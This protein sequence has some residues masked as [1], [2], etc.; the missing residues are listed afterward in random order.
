MKKLSLLSIAAIVA[1]TAAAQ[2][3]V[4]ADVSVAV[5]VGQIV[6]QVL[7][8]ADGEPLVGASVAVLNAAVGTMTDVNGRFV[9]T[10]AS[11]ANITVSYMGYW[12]KT[13]Q[14]QSQTPITIRLSID[15][16]ALDEVVVTGYAVQKR[17][18]VSGAVSKV[19]SKD[20]SKI[21]TPSAQMALQGRVAGV[22][23]SN[24]TGAPG[25][26]VSVRIRGVGSISSSN[27]PLY[28]VDGIPVEN[29]LNNISPGD[30]DNI[31]ILKDASSA[32]IYGAR[33]NNGVVLI[34]TKGGKAGKAVVSYNGQVGFQQHGRLTKMVNTAQYVELYNEAARADNV[35][36]PVPRALIEGDYVKD[37][38]DVN[39]LQEIFRIA[40][41]HSHELSV[42]G[43]TDKTQYLVGLSYFNQDGIILNTDYSRLG[44]RSNVNSKVKNWLQVGLN[45]NASTSL[46]GRVSSSGDGFASA[47]DVAAEGS[48]VADNGGSV[49]RYAFFRNPAI[50]VRNEQGVFVDK[51]S[52][53][54]GNSMY[55]SFFGDGYNPVGL[56]TNTDM[57]EKMKSLLISGNVLITLPLNF[58][59]KS[60]VGA[61][62]NNTLSRTFNA[63][64]GT[65]NRINAANSLDVNQTENTNITANATLNHHFALG[66]AHAFSWFAGTEA[67]SE[68]G[69][70]LGGSESGYSDLQYLGKGQTQRHPNQ[71]E[72]GATLLSFF[73]SLNYNY[74]QKYY[75]SLLLREDGSSRFAAGNRWGTFYSVSGSWNMES[76]E[77]MKSISAINKL[78]LRVGYGAIGNQNVGL[79]AN[80]SRYSAEQYYT[81]GGSTYNGYRMSKLGNT[82][83]KWETS[84]QFNAGVDLE[85]WQGSVG[86]AVDY[87][88]KITDK[89]LVAASYPPSVGSVEL[90]WVN[91]GSVLNTGVDVELFYRKD[92]SSSGFN[93]TLNGGFLHNEVL[94]LEAPIESGRVDQG[95]NATRTQVGHPIGAFYLYEMDGIFQNEM[96][97]LTSAY[98][99]RGIKPGDVKYKD[100]HADGTID[101]ADRVFAGSAIPAFTTG[102]TLS[103]YYRQWDL[104]VFFQGAFGQKIYVQVN[105]DIE[106]FYRGFPTTERYYSN[107]WTGEGSTNAYP[108][109]SWSAAQNNAKSGTTRFLEDGSY[110]RL[111]NI[112]LGYTVPNSKKAGIE[113]LR[114]YVSATNLLTLTGYSGLDPEMTASTNS[115]RAGEGDRANGIDWGTYPVAM[116]FTFGVNI[117]F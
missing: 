14:V 29:G 51:P 17:R 15:A 70:T 72:W 66:N 114:M 95:V 10:T 59:I 22:Q 85:L 117:T 13:L 86:V 19:D 1:Y 109:A 113:T 69:Q 20:L 39:Y 11:P 62:Y 74:A 4:N 31:T 41:L 47:S 26:A 18:D 68:N 36:A 9:L 6:G 100:N 45:I 2:I 12:S 8:D 65:A 96:E 92:F 61:D 78:K 23:V 87:Y 37:F 40:P 55:D 27:D 24:Q 34:T 32:A 104:S 84:K 7:D 77:F 30:I 99:G 44:V 91:N 80:Q 97:V 98:Q 54:F 43:G 93:I 89:M 76:E 112:Q 110:F 63:T 21:P 83:L 94:S 108:R 50:P 82:E 103:G 111:K 38:A 116:C 49:V 73:G 67:I 46:R 79:Y 102:L 56:A 101:A 90:P 81:F 60:T 58:S 3:N 88:Y 5:S 35:G 107:H 75:L 105:K 42:S 48:G 53:Y 64:W 71:G 57:T 52:E 115:S 33:A 25:S 106:G 28:I 16:R